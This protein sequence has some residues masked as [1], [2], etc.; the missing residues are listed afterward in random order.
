MSTTHLN[1][2][3]R[4]AWAAVA[5][6]LWA[7][8]SD[9]PAPASTTDANFDTTSDLADAT[10]RPDAGDASDTRENS[11]SSDTSTPPVSVEH[12]LPPV[13]QTGGALTSDSTQWRFMELADT[14]GLEQTLRFSQ[15][16]ELFVAEWEPAPS[17][18][19]VIDG[20]GPHFNEVSCA[21]CHPSSGRPATLGPDG[22]VHPGLLI[23]LVRETDQGRLPDPVF[24]P[25]FQPRSIAGV[26]PEGHVSWHAAATSGDKGHSAP[27]FSIE[28]H[29]SYGALH[30]DTRALGRASPHLVGLGLLDLVA[31]ATI[32]EAADPEDAD[33]D[34]IS[35]RPNIL[36]DGRLGRFGW[37]A[38]QPT[39]RGQSAMALAQDMGITSP[40]V[41]AENCSASQHDCLQSPSGGSPEVDEQGL[42][43]LVEY[44]RYVGVPAVRRHAGRATLEAGARHFDAAGCTGCHRPKLVTRAL[45]DRPLLSEQILHPFTDLLLHDMGE[46]LSDPAGE[47]NAGAREWRTAP[48]WGLGLVES[49]NPNARFLHDGRAQNLEEAILW[50]GGEADPARRYVEALN[51]DGRR[52]L[53]EF[54][55]SL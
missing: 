21:G 13:E 14:L 52:A 2:L 8:C 7:G 35:G 6:A 45:P 42:A 25:Q 20:L 26:A 50:H 27:R 17:S 39:L 10:S 37:K 55:R 4:L 9:A 5:A 24:G 31:D 23:R 19:P 36:D 3:Q 43:A 47:G 12:L 29:P 46:G 16:R 51:D 54:V 40:E 41:M 22:Q 48:L 44:Q 1:H 32:L 34:G 11:D 53:L 38:L 18:R 30:P 15:G 49:L 28:P 33:G